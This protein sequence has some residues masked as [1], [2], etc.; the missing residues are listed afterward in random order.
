[1]QK[2]LQI[3]FRGTAHSDAVEKNIRARAKKLD[4]FH[5]RIMAC[6][7]IVEAPHRHHHKGNMYQVRIDITVPEGELVV[8]RNRDQDQAH[9]DVYVAIRDAFRAARRQLEDY[10]RKRRGHVKSHEPPPHGRILAIYPQRDYG[11]IT[12]SDGREIYFH[13][14][15]VLDAEFDK[16]E[17]GMEVRFNEEAGDEGPKATTV[18]LVGKHHPVA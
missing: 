5:D 10:A 9:E 8:S 13:R 15:S 14:N 1:M 7:V 3:S 2:P 16:L 6:R 11:K 4:K 17:E 12:S 18:H